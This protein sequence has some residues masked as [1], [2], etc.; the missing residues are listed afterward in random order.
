M[1]AVG[2]SSSPGCFTVRTIELVVLVMRN[3]MQGLSI[4]GTW[5]QNET[6]VEF[7]SHRFSVQRNL[8][9]SIFSI[10]LD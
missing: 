5:R 1:A 9:C 3:W 8:Y 10:K 7:T 4:C 2:S 6:L